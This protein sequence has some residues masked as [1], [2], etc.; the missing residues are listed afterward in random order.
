MTTQFKNCDNQP[1]SPLCQDRIRAKISTKFCSTIKTESTHCESV[2]K[3][4]IY[5]RL[6]FFGSRF[7]IS[8]NQH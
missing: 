3:C 4:A 8:S 5:D 2:A 6:V 1:R 7:D